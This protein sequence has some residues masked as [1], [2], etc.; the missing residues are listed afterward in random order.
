MDSRDETAEI[1]L[2]GET[3]TLSALTFDQLQRVGPALD[4]IATAQG[5][6]AKFVAIRDVIAVAS[7]RPAAELDKLKV[8]LDE[9]YDALQVVI[10]LTGLDELGNRL[11]RE[12][13]KKAAALGD[14]KGTA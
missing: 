12:Q 8:R 3:L 14:I 9:L 5:L 7:G 11:A 6:T 10:R 2:G 1:T 4:S 13:A